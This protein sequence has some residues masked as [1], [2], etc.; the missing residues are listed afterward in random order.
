MSART[1]LA[2]L[3]LLAGAPASAAPTVILLSWDGM[4]HDGPERADAPALARMLREGARAERLVPVF[5]PNTFPAH[6]SLATGAHPDRHGI[7]DNRFFDRERGHYD[8][9]GD[10]GWIEAEPLWVAAERQ[11]VPAAVYF[12]VGSEGDWR[13]VGARYRVAPFDSGVGEARKVDQILHWLDLPEPERPRLI[14]A[15]WHGADAVGH[16][17]GPDDERVAEALREQARHLDRLFAGIDARGWRETTLLLV[18]DH[19]MTAVVGEI[20]LRAALA[21]SG[22]EV[23]KAGSSALAHLFLADSAQSARLAQR[24][25]ELDHV[26]VIERASLPA[27]LR[28]EHPTRTGDLV[29]LPDAGHVFRDGPLRRRL[30]RSFQR[31]LGRAT[32]MHGF[33]P[34]HP[35]MGGVFLA[36]GRGVPAGARLGPVRQIDVAPTVARLLGIESPRDAEGTPIRGIGEA[37]PPQSSTGSPM[38]SR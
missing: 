18:S 22:I 16:A 8:M 38:W 37:P 15:W 1:W 32:G 3:L 9:S 14:M 6:V 12:W 27:S 25:R 13:G 31:L 17:H 19:G 10:P 11:G 36:M 2:T 20:P 23:R 30:W 26:R 4:R 28:L 29:V 5:P 35:D 24:L 21:D 34:D 7:L 33:S